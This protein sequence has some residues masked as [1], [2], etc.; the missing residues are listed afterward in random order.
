MLKSTN[1]HL[2]AEASALQVREEQ[3]FLDLRGQGI[4]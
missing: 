2:L 4:N 3:G 1:S